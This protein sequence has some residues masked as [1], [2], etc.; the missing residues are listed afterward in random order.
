MFSIFRFGESLQFI[1]LVVGAALVGFGLQIDLILFAK[2]MIYSLLSIMFGFALNTYFDVEEDKVQPRKN[3]IV[4][5]KVSKQTVA[6]IAVLL[7]VLCASVLFIFFRNYFY[8]ILTLA[9]PVMYSAP[10]LRLKGRPV[11]DLLTH[12]A[13]GLILFIVPY[14][15]MEAPVNSYFLFVTI[16]VAIFSIQTE[17]VQELRDI[18]DDR[19]AR[20][21]TTAILLGSRNTMYLIAANVLAN[22]PLILYGIYM[23][24][25][26]TIDISSGVLPLLALIGL[27]DE[28]YN[29]RSTRFMKI[30]LIYF[31]IKR[32]VGW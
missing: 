13:M 8:L 10:P 18:N 24:I 30:F 26:S 1:L 31:A 22:I 19:K 28:G 3:L 5:K 32:V 21:R 17:L 2:V 20:L 14:L 9:V 15:L 12:A 23:R 6:L 4:Q 25:L 11:L 7:F 29:N 27:K 16:A